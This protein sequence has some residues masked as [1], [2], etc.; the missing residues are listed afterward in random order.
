MKKIFKDKKFLKTMATLAVPIIFQNLI[1]SSLNLVDNLMIGNLGESSIASVGLANQYFMVFMQTM[2][3]V[4]GGAILFMS[5]FFGRGDSKNIKRFLGIN[6]MVGFFV[7][8]LF[9]LIAFI[10]PKFIMGIFTSDPEVIALGTS[11]LKVVSISYLLTN[12]SLGF[13]S[14]LRSI[15]EAK[16]PMYASIIGLISNGFLNYMFIFGNFGMPR[17]G[18]AGAALGTTLS[19]VLEMTFILFMVYGKKRG[20]VPSIKELFDFDLS[21]V[22]TYFKAATPLILNDIMWST[23]ISAY[24]VAYG[25]L[26]TDSVATMQIAST[27]NNMFNIFGIGIA[28]AT[29]IMIGNKIGADDEEGAVDYSGRIS[30]LTPLV[31]VII[32][33]IV[34]LGTPYILSLFNINTTTYNNAFIVLKVM[35]IITPLRFFNIVMIIGVFRGGGDVTY[36]TLIEL[37][38][39]WG[40]AVP[41]AFIGAVIFKMPVYTLYIFVCLE[42]VF[43]IF[44]ELPRLKSKKWINNVIGEVA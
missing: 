12:I 44:F 9:A 22:K 42:E 20:I 35:A 11:Y 19:R 26:G 29:A 8:L 37:L 10:F 41:I 18:V 43:K 2:I 31:G 5:Q 25:K 3:G 14:A 40:I 32:G 1:T 4:N 23:G 39:V 15:G 34:F 7:S 6:L 13:S 36:A 33:A 24:S 27:I 17:L 16:I 30:I 21:L 28:N 38:A